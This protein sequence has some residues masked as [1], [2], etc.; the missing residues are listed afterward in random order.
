MGTRVTDL[1]NPPRLEGVCAV[2]TMSR[3]PESDKP[4]HVLSPR[5]DFLNLCGALLVPVDVF[6]L[7]TVVRSWHTRIED[8]RTFVDP[9]PAMP[10][11]AIMASSS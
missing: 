1:L 3:E 8:I 10:I 11:A 2:S 5:P 9:K 7:R 6:P 4:V